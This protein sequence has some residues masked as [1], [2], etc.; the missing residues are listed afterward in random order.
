M[1]LVYLG[2]FHLAQLF[3]LSSQ[4]FYLKI[5]SNFYKNVTISPPPFTTSTSPCPSP[6][7][8]MPPPTPFT[9]HQR[10]PKSTPYQWKLLLARTNVNRSRLSRRHT[11]AWQIRFSDGSGR[12]MGSR[13]A[14]LQCLLLIQW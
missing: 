13:S 12:S 8:R 14:N 7:I 1:F 5:I 3:L 6:S 11:I 4:M 9:R 2:F 10:A